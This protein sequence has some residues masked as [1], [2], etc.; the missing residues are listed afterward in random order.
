MHNIVEIPNFNL[1]SMEM[2]FTNVLCALLGTFPP[3]SV[4]PSQYVRL[5]FSHLSLQCQSEIFFSFP[6]Y[7]PLQ[8]ADL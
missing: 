8:P 5:P 1:F 4:L 7:Y 6:T 3:P 2:P